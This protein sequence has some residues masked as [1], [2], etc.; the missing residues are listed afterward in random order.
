LT[1]RAHSAENLV[2]VVADNY[3]FWQSAGSREH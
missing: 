2:D 1:G 3:S